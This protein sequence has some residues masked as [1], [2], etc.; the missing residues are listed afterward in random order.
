VIFTGIAYVVAGPVF[1]LIDWISQTP[2]FWTVFDSVS[3][4]G[5][6]VVI[7]GLIKWSR[8]YDERTIGHNEGR[9]ADRS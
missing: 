1:F 6:G 3:C 8:L 2:W 9:Y 4:F 5:L 7:L